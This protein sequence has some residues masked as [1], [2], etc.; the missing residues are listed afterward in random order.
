MEHRRAQIIVADDDADMRRLVVDTL[1]AD[2]HEIL[3]VGDGGRLL[4]LIARCCRGEATLPD[5]IVSDVRMP[6]MSGMGMLKGVRD[7]HWS[8]PVI[9][10]TAFPNLEL[11]WRAE[12]MAAR[13]LAKP[14]GL[15]ALRGAVQKALTAHAVA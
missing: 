15:Q 1:T 2:G 8:V 13:V 9:L 6:V 3:D 4:V 12:S 7:A 10:M 14:F 5:L 11:I